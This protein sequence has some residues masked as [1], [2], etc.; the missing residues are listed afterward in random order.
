[1]N[2]LIIYTVYVTEFELVYLQNW[3]EMHSVEGQAMMFLFSF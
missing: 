3:T 2:Y 1:M